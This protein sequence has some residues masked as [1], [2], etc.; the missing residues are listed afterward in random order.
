MTRVAIQIEPQY[1]FTF[2]DV[3]QIAR[4][5]E[6]CGYHALWTSDHLLWDEH[7]TRRYCLE[8]WTLLA[9]L[10][11]LTTTLRLAAALLEPDSGRAGQH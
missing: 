2:D 6:R 11:P 9:A 5:A 1:G 4:L 3:L 8:A 10:T 7:A